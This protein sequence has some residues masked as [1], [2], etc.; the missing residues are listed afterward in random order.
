M[1]RVDPQFV[2]CIR[3]SRRLVYQ[4][5]Y[6]RSASSA[7]NQALSSAFRAAVVTIR[8]RRDK[9]SKIKRAV[10]PIRTKSKTWVALR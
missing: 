4:E 9:L 5:D 10:F 8:T 2:C 6:N 7:P 1:W 3:A